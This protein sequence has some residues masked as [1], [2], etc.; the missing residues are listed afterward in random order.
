MKP[1]DIGLPEG[2]QRISRKLW[3]M[4]MKAWQHNQM[5]DGGRRHFGAAVQVDADWWYLIC[6]DAL[7]VRPN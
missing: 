7:S 3:R 6:K 4:E 5:M 2:S 1:E